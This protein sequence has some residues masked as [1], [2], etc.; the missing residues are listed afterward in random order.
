LEE[1]LRS[2]FLLFCNCRADLAKAYI[3]SFKQENH[4]HNNFLRI[5]KNRGVIVQAAPVEFALLIESILIPDNKTDEFDNLDRD[6]TFN[7]DYEFTNTSSA[8][9]LFFEILINA[10]DH[11]LALIQKLVDRA[12][13]YFSGGKECGSNA[14]TIRLPD[15]DKRFVWLDSYFWSRGQSGF[16]CISAALMAI[17]A[18]AHYR[19]EAGEDINSVLTNI[20]GNH[21]LP[22]AFLLV[23][24]DI[25]FSHWPNTIDV[26]IPFLSSP[27]LL[28]LDRARIVIDGVYYP[29]SFSDE[30]KG[31]VKLEDLTLRPSRKIRLDYLLSKFIF[32]EQRINRELLIEALKQASER[33]GKP[34]EPFDFDDPSFIALHALNKLNPENWVEILIM[35]PNGTQ[36]NGLQFQVPENELILLE[37]LKNRGNEELINANIQIKIS[38]A[39]DDESKSSAKF[40]EEAVCWAINVMNH[41]IIEESEQQYQREVSIISAAMIAMRDGSI[42]FCAKHADWAR[43]IFRKTLQISNVPRWAYQSGLRYNMKAIS[44]S[45]LIYLLKVSSDQKDIDTLFQALLRNY[46]VVANGFGATVTFLDAI[47]DRFPRALLR[48]ALSACIIPALYWNPENGLDEKSKKHKE[49]IQHAINAELGWLSEGLPEPNWPIFPINEVSVYK[50]IK[51]IAENVDYLDPPIE[52]KIPDFIF[53]DSTAGLWLGMTQKL[54]KHSKREWLINLAKSYSV[55]TSIING[56][57]M[58]SNI[59]IIKPPS[60]WNNAFYELLAYSLSSF[61]K[62]EI[63]QLVLNPIFSLPDNSFFDVITI[64]LRNIDDDFFNSADFE[65]ALA[66][67]LRFEFASKMMQTKGW[68]NLNVKHSFS[69]ERHIG[70]AIAVLFF[71]NYG[72]AKCYLTPIGINRLEIFLPVLTNLIESAPC[73]C[74]AISSLNLFEVSPKP[75]HIPII[76]SAANIWLR[77]FQDHTEF[78]IDNN[79]GRRL[80]LLFEKIL[81]QDL[82]LFE[83]VTPLRIEVDRILAALISLGLPEAK[84]LE[85]LLAKSEKLKN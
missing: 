85:E 52:Q 71:N 36:I 3:E 72:F 6:N 17:E 14:I 63:E 66:I 31:D 75:V 27:E 82:S 61:D 7:F 26:A 10:P 11:G 12:I 18:W 64:F 81:D 20:L 44:F 65:E 28:S 30:Q 33:L 69:I 16:Q 34:E 54:Y 21:N 73:F 35:Q 78:W 46:Q 48:C 58:D 32:P 60:K 5:L 19:I 74:V 70:P 15:G 37:T 13:L 25:V 68:K 4:N 43:E 77:D 84:Q 24:V 23:A 49:H 40:V 57:G 79:I 56:A 8:Q 59:D 47:D 2:N 39:V 50:G 38:S 45:G 29:N 55:W 53:D 76:I 42:E 41:P 62:E 67:Q 83:S 1:V 9:R 80:C 22:A 51:L